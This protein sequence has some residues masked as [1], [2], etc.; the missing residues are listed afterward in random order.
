MEWYEKIVKRK[1]YVADVHY[2]CAKEYEKAGRYFE[3]YEQYSI[4]MQLM[5]GGNPA[6]FTAVEI[7]ERSDAMIE[8]I[9]KSIAKDANDV[10]AAL[11]KKKWV[12]YIVIQSEYGWEVL[13]EVFTQRTDII[14]KEYMDY[15]KLPKLY[16][17][18]A[19]GSYNDVALKTNAHMSN[20]ITDYKVE[21]RRLCFSGADATVDMDCE[22]FLP[23]IM[24]QSTEFAVETEG[25]AYNVP[26]L[27]SKR[28]MTYRMPAG[29]S[30]VCSEQPFRLGEPISIGHDPKRKHLVLNIFV[31]G[32]SQIALGEKFATLMPN[33]Y[34]F[35]SKGMVCDN[36]YTAGDWTFPSI[37]SIVTGQTMAKHQMLHSKL[38]RKI[39]IDTPILYEYFKDAGYHTVKIGGNWRI[40]PSYGYARGM[41]RV[42]YQNHYVGYLAES[43]VSD[44]IEQMHGMRDVDQFIWMEIGELHQIADEVDIGSCLSEFT[45][46]NIRKHEKGVNSVKQLYDPAKI[47]YYLKQIEKVD[48]KLAAL[49]QYIEDHYAEE[50]ILVSLFSDHGQGYLVKPEE[51]FLSKGRSNIAFMVRG[52]G[53]NGRTEEVIS[54]CDYTAIMCKLAGVPY[55]FE[56][57]DA[58][59]PEIFGGT[60]KREFAIAESIHVGDPYQISLKGDDFVFYLKG[61]E[62]VT[63]ECRI[64]LADY[65]VQ[66]LD[67]EEKNRI[68]D[69]DKI[70]YYTQYCLE[71]IDSCLLA[72]G[73]DYG[74]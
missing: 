31:D 1:P 62:N 7:A 3:A 21:L 54:S 34:R 72:E 30:R 44:V 17:G 45:L 49:Y 36:V 55:A 10:A 5:Q 13:S 4:A 32:L 59:L 16:I 66:L 29:K 24:D 8:K 61:K 58:H 25:N 52:S 9:D 6:S 23:V 65:S 74:R 64:P 48:R 71:H 60:E 18:Y 14:T 35:F 42:L 43:I 15:A 40:I 39:D 53:V 2:V 33:T 11:E 73:S 51:E 57:T 50:E 27:Q 70:N 63:S 37:A 22:Y 56:N 38:R 41:D 47:Q 20:S 26:Y 46:E 19:S 68:E 28:Y 12:D 67:R 69:Q